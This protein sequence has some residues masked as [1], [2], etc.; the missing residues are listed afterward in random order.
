[1]RRKITT[2]VLTVLAAVILFSCLTFAASGTISVSNA[3][4]TEGSNVTVTVKTSI[5]VA[6]V[7]FKLKY[8]TSCLEFVS[9]SGSN[10]FTTAPT[11]E[12]GVIM[13]VDNCPEG[14]AIYSA[15]IT[16]K[17]LKVGKSTISV[18]SVDMVC[19][20]VGDALSFT[21]G[22]GTVTVNARPTASSDA[23]LKSLSISPGKLSPA[24]SSSNTEYS[25]SVSNSVT[26]IAVTAKTNHSAAKFSVSGNTKLAVGNNTVRIKVTAE[27][28]TVKTYVINVKRAEAPV[29]E[30]DPTPTEPEPTPEK[31]KIKTTDGSELEVSDFEDSNIPAGFERTE[32]VIGEE[33]V[34]AIT[35]TA[36]DGNVALFLTSGDSSAFCYYD[37]ETQTADKIKT[38]SGKGSKYTVL[39]IPDTIT[40]PDGYAKQY[41]TISDS[42]FYAFAPEDSANESYIIYALNSEGKAGLYVYDISEET[43]QR[44]GI[45]Y[46]TDTDNVVSEPTVEYKEYPEYYK[47]I[48]FGAAGGACLFVILF[49]IFFILYLKTNKSYKKLLA[50]RK[51]AKER[52]KEKMLLMRAEA[53]KKEAKQTPEES[54]ALSV[55]AEEIPTILEESV[56]KVPE[57]TVEETAEKEPEE[58]VEEDFDTD[59]DFI[60]R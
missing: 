7:Q 10:G 26:S 49:V 3:T 47:W 16:F 18:T 13:I 55:T 42:A 60:F 51:R 8:D 43:I 17:P 44:Y 21:G 32:I 34:S 45:V 28:G 31:L 40:A 19:D 56:G 14:S 24:F 9:Y 20:T 15:T 36:V 58:T 46:S 33:T 54:V 1:M 38:V 50:A 29:V 11:V 27:N 52:R 48:F 35:A 53:E 5:A 41:L 2:A 23:T 57:E 22:S 59:I 39:N 30:P 12:N 25:V 4:V 37:A 6:G